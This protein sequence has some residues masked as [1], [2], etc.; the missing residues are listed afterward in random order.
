[1]KRVTTWLAWGMLALSVVFILLLQWVLSLP[2]PQKLDIETSGNS[3]F[4]F[5]GALA[6]SVVGAL[7]LTR[8][9]THPIGWIYC[10]AGLLVGLT[11]FTTGYAQYAKMVPDVLPAGY[12]ADAISNFSFTMGFFLPIT[13]GLLL[14]PDG[15]LPSRRWTPAI[16]L[17]VL[18]F[19]LSLIGFPFF[20]LFIAV[21]PSAASLIMRWRRA[22]G[23]ERQQLKW[24]GSAATLLVSLLLL[25]VLFTLLSSTWSDTWAFL[26][27]TFAISLI[28]IAA[29]I[30]ILK[31]GLYEIDILINRTLVYVPLTAILAGL[32][33][34]TIT[35]SQRIF[36]ALTGQQSDGATVL[37][38]LVVVAAFTPVKDGLQARV[39]KRFKETPDP[40]KKLKAYGN[41]VDA[42]VHVLRADDSARRLLDE[43]MGAFDAASGAVFL[44]RDA[45][46]Q[47]VQRYGDS[48]DPDRLSVPLESDGKRLGLLT[49]GAR[50]SGLKYTADERA[51]VQQIANSVAAAIALTMRMDGERQ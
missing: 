48:S 37:T 17:T 19:V 9:P 16:W 45:E 6:F 44:Q 43:A 51:T 29:G 20:I 5:L 46:M 33:A 4:A 24:I 26:M 31:Y 40:A 8:R 25:D 35:L 18:C 11:A 30:A 39:D 28:P 34:G 41:Q 32:Y 38:T 7:I 27:A 47:L 1:M 10:T 2:H 42:V 21:V 14:F 15:Y 49:L 13:F 22:R 3:P 23:E 12:L 36:V 50:R